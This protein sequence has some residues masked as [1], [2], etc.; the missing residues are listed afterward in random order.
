MFRAAAF[1]LSLIL[2]RPFVASA[3]EHLDQRCNYVGE[4][5]G[6]RTSIPLRWVKGYPDDMYRW[7]CI[8]D[9]CWGAISHNFGKPRVLGVANSIYLGA[10]VAGPWKRTP[11][12]ATKFFGIYTPEQLASQEVSDIQELERERNLTAKWLTMVQS[13]GFQSLS[14]VEKENRIFDF[15]IEQFPN[16]ELIRDVDPDNPKNWVAISCGTFF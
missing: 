2:F 4:V 1:V 16:G 6:Q 13:A 14:R 12:Q 3:E 10:G 8:K 15:L 5:D 9:A 11:G 7:E